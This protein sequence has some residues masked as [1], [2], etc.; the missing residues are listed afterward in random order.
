MK[1]SIL[2]QTETRFT[3]DY[4]LWWKN[5]ELKM[6]KSSKF[7]N[8]VSWNY[9]KYILISRGAAGFSYALGIPETGFK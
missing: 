4:F 8:S 1:K 9:I 6:F 7:V 3:W 2:I 5:F